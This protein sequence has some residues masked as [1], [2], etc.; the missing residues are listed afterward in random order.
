MTRTLPGLT[1]LLVTLT[2]V[3]ASVLRMTGRHTERNIANT[4]SPLDH[5]DFHKLIKAKTAID[6]QTD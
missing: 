4:L 3:A 2:T 1:A 6:K 5:P